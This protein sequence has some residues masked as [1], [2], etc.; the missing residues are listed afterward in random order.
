MQ[1]ITSSASSVCRHRLGTAAYGHGTGTPGNQSASPGQLKR[2][3]GGHLE[4]PYRIAALPETV[5]KLFTFEKKK[6]KKEKE[7]MTHRP[8][9]FAKKGTVL[10]R[11][12][13]NTLDGLGRDLIKGSTEELNTSLSGFRRS[14]NL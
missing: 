11:A 4:R 12:L 14:A 8:C 6:L 9:S 3:S 7:K 5:S 2:N 13:F 1:H 10:L